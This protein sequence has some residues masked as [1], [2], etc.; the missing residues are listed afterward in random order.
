VLSSVV[1]FCEVV[2]NMTSFSAYLS[3]V[4]IFSVLLFVNVSEWFSSVVFLNV[5]EFA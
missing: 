1:L 4:I 5:L 3:F 2:R